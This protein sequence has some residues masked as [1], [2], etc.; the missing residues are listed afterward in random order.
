VLLLLLLLSLG[1]K[2]GD[3]DEEEKEKEDGVA[4]QKETFAT[5]PTLKLPSFDC[6]VFFFLSLRLRAVQVGELVWR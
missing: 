3:E 1:Y 4:L 6:C 2:D 5:W